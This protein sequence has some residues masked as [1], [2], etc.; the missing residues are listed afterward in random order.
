[1]KKISTRHYYGTEQRILW[2]YNQAISDDFP[3]LFVG[4]WDVY[5]TWYDHG[6][7]VEGGLSSFLLDAT[8]PPAEQYWTRERF[9][10]YLYG[11]LLSVYF[12][13]ESLQAVKSARNIRD[14]KSNLAFIRQISGV[15]M[16]L[17]T[18]L[19]ALSCCIYIAE[20]RIP[21]GCGQAQGE[22][23]HLRSLSIKSVKEKINEVGAYGPL[24]SLV[25]R[26]EFKYLSD[27]RNLLAHRLFLQFQ[28]DSQGLL[29]LPEDLGQL[30]S[31]TQRK[32]Q[33]LAS[34]VGTYLEA[35]LGIIVVDFEALLR[36]LGARYRKRI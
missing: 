8:L 9:G 21:A 11:S 27:Y 2:I 16:N 26:S 34:D 20:N 29:H 7:R 19:D 17:F 5:E 14:V 3:S 31:I 25:D 30:D 32:D 4:Y 36:E 33:Y 22:Q 18:A 35:A 13:W 10:N 12:S 15:V 23:K 24:D 28:E 6:E 1:M